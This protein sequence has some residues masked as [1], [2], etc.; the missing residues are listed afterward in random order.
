M[1][2]RSI[3]I[4]TS[5][6]I[7]SIGSTGRTSNTSTARRVTKNSIRGDTSQ[8]PTSRS[9]ARIIVAVFAIPSF[10]LIIELLLH[11]LKVVLLLKGHFLL[12]VLPIAA[13]LYTTKESVS[14]TRNSIAN[15]TGSSRTH[16]TTKRAESLAKI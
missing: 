10:L 4:T 6:R 3:D 13:G 14:S 8:T 11:V 9:I 12:F 16:Q 5:G 7:R 2:R 15:S 1:V